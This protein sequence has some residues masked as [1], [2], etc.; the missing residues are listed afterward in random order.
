MGRNPGLLAPRIYGAAAGAHGLTLSHKI[1]QNLVQEKLCKPVFSL[2][3][4]SIVAFTPEGQELG[5]LEQCMA[6]EQGPPAPAA[7][8]QQ[9]PR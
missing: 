3:R 5:P 4:G 7:A 2:S 6:Q 8:A 1:M 9:A